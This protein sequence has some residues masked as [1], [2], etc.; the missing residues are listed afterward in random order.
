MKQKKNTLKRTRR[1][2][3]KKAQSIKAQGAPLKSDSALSK[4]LI[5]SGI[6]IVL[7][8]GVVLYNLGTTGQATKVQE[9][10]SPVT[11]NLDVD[12]E[13]VIN[14]DNLKSVKIL[15]T[16]TSEKGSKEYT[17]ELTK[18]EGDGSLVYQLV[19]SVSNTV[20]ARELITETIGGGVLYLPGDEFADLEVSYAVPYF[21]IKNLNFKEPEDVVIT[22]LTEDLS[23]SSTPYVTVAPGT[24]IVLLFNATSS[25]QPELMVAWANGTEFTA[26]ELTQNATGDLFITK[27]LEWTPT[28]AGANVLSVMGKI[29]EK[30]TIKQYVIAAGN[31]VYE[32][33]EKNVPHVVVKKVA[34]SNA[35]EV[36]LTFS[37]DAMM[38]PFSLPC[39]GADLVDGVVSVEMLGKIDTISSYSPSALGSIKQWAY[40]VPSDFKELDSN[41]GYFLQRKES[42]VGD[43]VLS[44]TCGANVLAPPDSIS[45]TQPS[46]KTGWNLIGISGYGSIKVDKLSLPPYKEVTLVYA[47]DNDGSD[48]TTSSI[49]ELQPGRAYW[50]R[51]E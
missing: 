7:I 17:L 10:P 27:R 42:A 39:G 50:V 6:V 40:Q 38:Q 45:F 22:L 14:V 48:T 32:L 41:K 35:A 44:V 29:G 5:I 31:I 28:I 4:I 24:K 43:I 34:K 19:N 3:T 15:V 33:S 30:Q 20:A 12:D 16:P 37:D 1:T 2:S 11:Y 9:T 47:I 26:E 36:T 13:Q 8:L 21:H 25:D 23:E 18:N 51:V 49:T 46:L